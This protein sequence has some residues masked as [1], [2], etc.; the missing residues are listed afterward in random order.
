M[1]IAPML[2]LGRPGSGKSVLAR[3]L[4]GRLPPNDFMPVLVE[5]RSVY[6]GA[7]VQEQIEQAIRADTG[8]RVD[9]PVRDRG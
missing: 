9:W 4:A 5:L 2:L 6:A 3:L 1:T 8:E 7:D